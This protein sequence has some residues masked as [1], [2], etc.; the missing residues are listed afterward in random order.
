MTGDP[1]PV[2]LLVTAG[3]RDEAERLGEG[4][5]EARLAACGSVIP[6]VHSFF[7]WQDRI[8]REHEAILL[9]K[10]V[11]SLVAEAEAYIKE[12]HSYELPEI[13]R[14]D[15]A[16]GYGPYLAWVLGETAG[17]GNS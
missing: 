2:L 9:V 1:T 6:M 16:G 4:L 17:S 10:T 7:R 15:I 12:H 14:I 11:S 13:L 3:T 5:V 8:Q